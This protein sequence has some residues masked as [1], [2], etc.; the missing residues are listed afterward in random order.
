MKCNEM[1]YNAINDDKNVIKI[2]NI[3][4]NNEKL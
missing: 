3:P 1:K 2:R 4:K